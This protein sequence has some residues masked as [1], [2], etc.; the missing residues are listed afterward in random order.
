MFEI[1]ANR[2]EPDYS[3]FEKGLKNETKNELEAYVKQNNG[4][5]MRYTDPRTKAVRVYR[6]K[7]LGP[8]PKEAL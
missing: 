8:K 3:E 4:L 1:R 7:G 5:K 2:R 6:I